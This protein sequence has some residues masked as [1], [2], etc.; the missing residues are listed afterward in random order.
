MPQLL[1]TL[2]DFATCHPCTKALSIKEG[3]LRDRAF[4]ALGLSL[5]E[6]K[7]KVNC[8]L[9]KFS[10]LS[11]FSLATILEGMK[12]T[13]KNFVVVTQHFQIFKRIRLRNPSAIAR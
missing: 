4:M 8:F 13:L 2:R 5:L 1:R 3:Y 6:A 11:I 12:K 10:L 7:L 9:A